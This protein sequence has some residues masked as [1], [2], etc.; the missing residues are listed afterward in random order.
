MRTW[1]GAVALAATALLA[2]AT[3]GV[4]DGG[5]IGAISG[6]VLGAV[7][8]DSNRAA[9]T[10]VGATLG[11]VFGALIGVMVADPEAA[12]PDGDDDGI[13]DVQD[14]CPG[15][16]NKTQQDADGDGAGDAC[17]P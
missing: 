7:S 10:L 11:G 14:N 2:C 13:S 5:T 17:D 9:A 6:A 15:K 12:G 8:G 16:P 3:P 4:R 1:R